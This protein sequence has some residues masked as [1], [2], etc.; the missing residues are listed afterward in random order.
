MF[1]RNRR[2][3]TTLLALTMILSLLAGCGGSKPAEKKEE[4]AASQPAP[5]PKKVTITW[6]HL[7]TGEPEAKWQAIAD[8]YTKANPH[9][10]IEISVL[11]NEAF[12]QKIATAMQSGSPP[13]LFNSWGGGGLREYAKAG[14]LKDITADLNKDGWLATLANADMMTS[15]GKYYGVPVNVGMVGFWY[16]KALFAKAG[17]QAPPKTWDEFLSA[18]QKLKAA[19]ITPIAL[20]EGEKW[21]GAFYWE[22][23]ALRIG[24]KD[25][26]VKAYT[27]SGGKFSDP[28]FV[29]AGKKLQELIALKPF[30]DGFLGATFAEEST[31]VATEKAAMELMGHWALYSMRDNSPDK[32]GLGDKL[33]WF[34]FPMVAGGKGDP[35]DALG[36]GDGIA[37]GKNAPPEAVDFLRFLTKVENLKPLV[38]GNN[39]VPV[40]KGAE[41]YVTDPVMKELVVTKAKAPYLQLYYD[42]FLPPAS[43]AAVNDHVQNL[44]AGKMTPEQAAQEIEKAAAADLK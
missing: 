1:K 28:A 26:F 38:E 27:R 7:W 3:V 11:E 9:V 8:A 16:N 17:I 37:V 20:G 23:L 44:F 34:P 32:K 25:A 4:P 39:I 13:D 40:T 6:W 21:P 43:G 15:D 2:F 19:G 31:L 24:G 18:V 36:G 41:Q 35:N 33:G 29:E 14:L 30:Q 12:K 22:Y 42:Q 10:T 5:A